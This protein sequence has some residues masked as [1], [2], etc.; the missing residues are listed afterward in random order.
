M[1]VQLEVYYDGWC[2]ICTGIRDRL[3]RLDRRG[4]L[5]FC[6]MREEGVPERVGVPAEALAAR[7]HVRDLRSGRVAEGITAVRLLA[8]TL[9]TLWPL[10]PAIWV[11]EKVGLGGWLYDWIA[12]RRPIVPV[13]HC[14][15]GACPIHSSK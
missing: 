1:S 7:M 6:S 2:S 14:K 8:A 15:D 12:A 11:S 9:P 3:E 10:W 4:R 13:G 5:A